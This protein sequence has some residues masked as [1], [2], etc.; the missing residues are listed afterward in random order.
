MTPSLHVIEGLDWYTLWLQQPTLVDAYRCRWPHMGDPSLFPPSPCTCTTNNTIL[1]ATLTVGGALGASD[2]PQRNPHG[3]NVGL[4]QGNALSY[5]VS[6]YRNGLW[7]RVPKLLLVEVR[8]GA[9]ECGA[10]RC[11]GVR[12]SAVHPFLILVG[13]VPHTAA[14]CSFCMSYLVI[15]FWRSLL[16]RSQVL[17]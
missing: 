16:M 13:I 2:T 14:N 5:F 4:Q 7:Q 15:M 1:V 10:V 8:C 3:V 12:W 6:V 9:V 17:C 11:D